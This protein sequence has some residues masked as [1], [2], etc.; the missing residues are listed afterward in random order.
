[1]INLI[2]KCRQCNAGGTLGVVFIVVLGVA[3]SGAARWGSCAALSS[4]SGAAAGGGSLPRIKQS[5]TGALLAAISGLRAAA[6]RRLTSE[7]RLRAQCGRPCCS[8]PQSGCWPVVGVSRGLKNSPLDC[9]LRTAVRRPV[10]PLNTGNKKVPLAGIR[11]RALFYAGGG[12]RT[13]TVSPPTDFESAQVRRTW[14][15]F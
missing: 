8:T 7:T 13:H 4:Q 2:K 6:A 1:M 5:S 15:I 11:P 9:F 12:G 10:R 14:W 3:G